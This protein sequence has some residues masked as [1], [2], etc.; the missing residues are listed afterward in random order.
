M[1][2]ICDNCGNI[3]HVLVDGYDFGDR[4]MEGVMFKVEDKDGKPHAIGVIDSCKEYFEDFN[5]DTWLRR[6]E[7]FCEDL[8]IAECP[9]C[10]GDVEV[11][12]IGRQ[13]VQEGTWQPLVTQ[14]IKEI[15]VRNIGDILKKVCGNKPTKGLD[16]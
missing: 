2:L 15:P 4:V 7:A 1:K 3:D 11:W 9:N 16:K 13:P 5:K 10:G 6:C 8:D 14:P 12:D